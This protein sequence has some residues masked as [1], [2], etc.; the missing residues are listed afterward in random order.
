MPRAGARRRDDGRRLRRQPAADRVEADRQTRSVPRSTTSDLRRGRVGHDHV[1]VRA[2]LPVRIRARARRGRAGRCAH[3]APHQHPAGV[4]T[5]C[6]CRSWP[7]AGAGRPR[8]TA[9]W[10]GCCPPVDCTASGVSA[11]SAATD[12]RA[13][14]AL[15]Q[16]VHRVEHRQP[17][18]PGQ[19]RRRRGAR[20]DAEPGQRTRAGSR[21]QQRDALA[22][23]TALRR[24]A[25][26]V[27][28]FTIGV[29]VTIQP[30][31]PSKHFR[32]AAQPSGT[33]RWPGQLSCRRATYSTSSI[34][35]FRAD[36]RSRASQSTTGTSGS[37]S[38][39]RRTA[40][41][42]NRC[43]ALE[44]V[45]RHHERRAALLEVVDRREAVGQP[46]GVGQHHRAERAVRQL[47]PEEPEPVLARA[48][49]T[50]RAAGPR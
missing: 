30:D 1:R 46:A 37:R 6:R 45:D 8:T 26:D 5:R 48:C 3:P 12:E 27:D 28:E 41:G 14:R 22:L 7:R 18:V 38:S 44:A 13:D 47:V 20:S 33:R 9:R 10:H 23:A 25:A 40:S 49:R 17:R 15:V 24:V 2:G 31:R 50:G 35:T 32:R 11:P 16:L 4:R 34:S 21:L 19:E 36:S 43:C 42:A 39:A 29:H